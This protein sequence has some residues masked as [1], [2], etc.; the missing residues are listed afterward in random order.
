MTKRKMPTRRVVASVLLC[1]AAMSFAS[2]CGVAAST[3]GQAARLTLREALEIAVRQSPEIVGARQALELSRSTS[4]EARASRLPRISV[5]GSHEASIHPAA[6]GPVSSA[7]T[8]VSLTVTQ[9]LPSW[10]PE[11]FGVG[12]SPLELATMNL[13]LAEIDLCK[14]EQKV[15]FDVTSAYLGVLRSEEMKA[16]C[17]AAIEAAARFLDEVQSKLALGIATDLDLMRAQ[18]QLDQARFNRVKAEDDLDGARRSLALL[19]GLPA[20]TQF[21]LASDFRVE[22]DQR[23]LEELVPLALERRPELKQASIG[24]LKAE[25]ALETAKRSLWPQVSLAATHTSRGDVS[26]TAGASVS[27]TSGEATWKAT[28]SDDPPEGA[29]PGGATG[30]S[31]PTSVVAVDVSWLLGDGGV[32]REKVRQAEISLEMQRSE[33][34]RQRQAVIEDVRSAQVGQRQAFLKLRLAEEAARE[35]EAALRVARARFE[36]G[37][38]VLAEVMEAD[39]SLDSAKA[40]A[41]SALFD[42]YL[43]EARL[44]RALGTLGTE[45]QM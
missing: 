19:L 33:L 1:L 41:I 28:L 3:E 20:E 31:A 10:L 35:A 37:V 26:F 14:T 9:S 36:A 34:S 27:L 12:L 23:K 43:A 22:E 42:C 29:T 6:A 24:V 44:A 38:A 16:L 18:N 25:A 17:D 21:E 11:P 40:G 32:G 4:A 8:S 45:N 30:L 39:E 2:P 15:L 5:Q 13:Q 7:D